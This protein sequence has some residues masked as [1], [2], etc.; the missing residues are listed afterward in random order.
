MGPQAIRHHTRGLALALGLALL[1]L[2]PSTS[3]AKA[4]KTIEAPERAKT[5][6]IWRDP[7]NIESRNLFYGAGGEQDQ[8]HA[9]FKFVEEDVNGTNPK[10]VIEDKD[11]V[12][13]TVKLGLE[14][15]PEIAATRLV[16][17]AGYFTNEDYFLA[18]LR[19]DGM[20]AHLKRGGDKIGAGGVI[21]D[22]RLKRHNPGEKKIDN[23]KWRG[24]TDADARELNGLRVM[25][26]LVNNWDLKDVNNE[27]YREKD[28]PL[29]VYMVSDLGA[30]F[31]AGSLTFPFHRSKGDV[32][33]Y[34][35][36]TFIRNASAEYVDFGTP[37]RP[38][39]I[40][41]AWPPRFFQRLPLDRLSKHVPRS[42][43][44]FM[45]ELLSRLSH[46]Q[47]RDAFRAAE[48]PATDVDRF[49]AT[50]ESRIAEL[51]GL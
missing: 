31:G 24:N 35:H 28:S 18:E 37:G 32:S 29:P 43:A 42:D 47:I 13:W 30:S 40:Y 16:W 19:V 26:A 20:P 10:Y 7:V 6:L 4:R 11:H 15:R 2:A 34:T 21:H 14:A 44:K 41:V 49:S 33:A 1:S 23:W 27:I 45:G 5:F 50:V 12:K 38:A 48:Y 25:M 51:N 3:D 8:P 46:A 17:A 22:A 9:P 39:L 36:S